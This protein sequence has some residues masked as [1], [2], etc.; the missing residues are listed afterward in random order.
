MAN[1]Q[2]SIF[3]Q[4]MRLFEWEKDPAPNLPANPT[5]DR[6][7]Q[8]LCALGLPNDIAAFKARYREVS[9]KDERLVLFPLEPK[10]VEN[11]FDPLRQAKDELSP[12]QL[13]RGDRPLWDGGGESGHPDSRDQHT[14][15]RVS[16]TSLSAQD[17]PGASKV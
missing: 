8:F 13:S 11:L 16:G 15:T 12:G 6:L 5:S 4:P 1:F 3:L 9:K 10:L 2:L 14:P 17:R 7:L